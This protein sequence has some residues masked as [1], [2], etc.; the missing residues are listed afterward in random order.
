MRK[1]TGLRNRYRNG[2]S[3]YSAKNKR[4]DADSYGSW[5]QGRRS[6]SEVIAGKSLTY[7]FTNAVKGE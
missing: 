6:T 1:R 7:R 3:V 4:R 2:R 5:T